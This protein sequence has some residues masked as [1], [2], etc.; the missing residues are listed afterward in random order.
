MT[1][2]ARPRSAHPFFHSR[3]GRIH[4]VGEENGEQEC[5]QGAAGD[6]QKAE[7]QREQQ[8]L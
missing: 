1:A 8:T 5:D 3:D 7:R 2:M 4:Q 6:V